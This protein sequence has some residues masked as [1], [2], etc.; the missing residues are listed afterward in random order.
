MAGAILRDQRFEREAEALQVLE[1]R[2]DRA[3]FVQLRDVDLRRVA[4]AGG[5]RGGI[6]RFPRWRVGL[7]WG[8]VP[9]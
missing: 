5:R 7:R 1:A 2:V 3:N 6:G 4:I 8:R 9:R